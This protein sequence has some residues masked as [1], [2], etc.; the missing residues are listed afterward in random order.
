[1]TNGSDNAAQLD[2]YFYYSNFAIILTI[3]WTKFTK[4]T[5]LNGN[6]TNFNIVGMKIA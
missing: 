5:L 6:P 3:L 2:G 4:T 1:M